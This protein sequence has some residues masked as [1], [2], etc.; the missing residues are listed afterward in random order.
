MLLH[1]ITVR[2]KEYNFLQHIKTWDYLDIL[3]ILGK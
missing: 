2:Y 3:Y 1:G